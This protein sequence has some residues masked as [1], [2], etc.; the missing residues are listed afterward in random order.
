LSH[1]QW[2]VRRLR[3]VREPVWNDAMRAHA[4]V[5]RTHASVMAVVSG[6]ATHLD[7]YGDAGKQRQRARAF[8]GDVCIQLAGLSYREDQNRRVGNTMR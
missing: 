5:M 2:L 3:A 6:G 7:R 4:S 1:V 8:S